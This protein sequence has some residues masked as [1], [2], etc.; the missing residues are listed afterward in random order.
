MRLLLRKLPNPLS[1]F[2]LFVVLIL[3]ERWFSGK[4]SCSPPPQPWSFYHMFSMDFSFTA[5][6][7]HLAIVSS[8]TTFV[9]GQSACTKKFCKYEPMREWATPAAHGGSQARGVIGAT[10]ANLCHSHSNAGS[11]LHLRPTPQLR[12]TPDS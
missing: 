1:S 4:T 8:L 10:A 12:A 6:K 11:E 3:A 5:Y 7:F 2:C 9:Y